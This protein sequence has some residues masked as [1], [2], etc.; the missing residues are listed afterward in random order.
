[1]FFFSLLFFLFLS[2]LFFS[3]FLSILISSLPI[4]QTTVI[5]FHYLHYSPFHNFSHS[6]FLVFYVFLLP[7]LFYSSLPY[8]FRIFLSLRMVSP[9]I[10]QTTVIFPL[11]QLSSFSLFFSFSR[12][13]V[14]YVFLL[15]LIFYSSLPYS[16]LI[17]CLYSS[18]PLPSIK[19]QSSF[20]YLH[21]P[22]F[23]Y[24][25]PSLSL[26]FY[27]F[28]LPLIFFISLFPLLFSFFVFT[29]LFP[30]HPSNNSHLSIISTLLLFPIF[31]LLYL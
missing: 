11:S 21:S 6:L 18:L 29:H 8:S 24:F 25:S 15:P 16:F 13:L 28:L 12:S 27:V 22:P 17:F 5:F 20:H 10:H 31:L 30:S 14:F 2:S 3:H 1:M 19:Q 7:L 23:Q 26:V 4:H 9:P